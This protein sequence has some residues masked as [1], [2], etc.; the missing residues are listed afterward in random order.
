MSLTFPPKCR[1]WWVDVMFSLACLPSCLASRFHGILQLP[2]YG[3]LGIISILDSQD[4]GPPIISS[5]SPT[6]SSFQGF[7]YIQTPTFQTRVSSSLFIPK[8]LWLPKPGR[9]QASAPE[10]F[11]SFL[12]S[13]HGHADPNSAWL[14]LFDL[15]YRSHLW[16]P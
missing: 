11:L 7:G 1:W 12:F 13:I 14:C 2:P 6:P 8:D 15:P 4:Y 3:M 16:L 5:S 9:S 10:H